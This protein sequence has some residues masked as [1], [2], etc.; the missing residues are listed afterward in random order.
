MR[1]KLIFIV[2]FL[3]ICIGVNISYSETSLFSSLN[4]IREILIIVSIA[5]FFNK[6][7]AEGNEELAEEYI[8]IFR[9][10]AVI[11]LLAQLPITVYQFVQHGPSDAVEGTYGDKGSGV[12]TLSVVCLVF[13]LH[14]FLRNQAQAILLYVTLV[15]LLLNETKISFIL[16]PLLMLFIYF[17][18][19]FK[20]IVLALFAAGFFLFLVNQYYSN[21]VLNFDGDNLAGIFSSD[22]SR[23]LSSWRYLQ[24]G[25]YTEIHQNYC[26]LAIAFRSNKYISFWL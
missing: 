1:S 18:L 6:V 13:F 11:F 24:S 25:R 9:K 20:N 15:P 12:L 22:F 16:I 17:R 23:R 3:L 8:R 2:L 10:F 26:C 21:T 5:I 7:F 14:H 19:K 4:G